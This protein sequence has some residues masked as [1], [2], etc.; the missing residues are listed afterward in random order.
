MN[1][2]RLGWL[3]RERLAGALYPIARGLGKW[4][5]AIADGSIRLSGEPEL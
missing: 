4:S 2:K 5:D 1:L 3:E